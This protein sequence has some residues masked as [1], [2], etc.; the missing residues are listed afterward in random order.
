MRLLDSLTRP[1]VGPAVA[2][3]VVVVEIGAMAV[4]FYGHK[5]IELD[6]HQVGVY[7]AQPVILPDNHNPERAPLELSGRL[8]A[9]VSSTASTTVIGPNWFIPGGWPPSST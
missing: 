5:P 2:G 4:H 9:G 6:H 7:A 1:P 8:I 3:A